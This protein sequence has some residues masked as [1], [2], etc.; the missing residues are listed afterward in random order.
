MHGGHLICHDDV[1]STRRVSYIIYLT[2]PEEE[3][4]AEDGGSLELYPVDNNGVS[5]P[6]SLRTLLSRGDADRSKHI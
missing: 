5:P 3:W 4:T 6:R 1:I 2:D